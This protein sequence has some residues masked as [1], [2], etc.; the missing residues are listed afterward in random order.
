MANLFEDRERGYEAKWAHDEETHFKIVSLRNARLAIWAAEMMHLPP[1][2]SGPYAE[3]LMTIGMSKKEDDA[4]VS[5][6]QQDFIARGI[7]CPHA[8]LC[9]KM[10]EFHEQAAREF[11]NR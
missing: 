6:I 1:E 10:R 9:Q 2:Q 5:K 4:V 11:A 3:A 7:T 8:I